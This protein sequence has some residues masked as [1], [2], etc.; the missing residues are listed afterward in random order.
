MDLDRPAETE[1]ECQS[2]ALEFDL[3]RS[4]FIAAV[5]ERY[6][7]AAKLRDELADLRSKNRTQTQT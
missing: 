3:L 1:G 5:E 2:E 6:I 7:D 4:M